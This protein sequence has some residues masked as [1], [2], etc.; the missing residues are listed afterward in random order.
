MNGL[1][2]EDLTGYLVEHEEEADFRRWLELNHE[3]IFEELLGDW[4][5][6]PA[7]WLQDRSMRTLHEWCHFDFHSLVVDMGETPIED[8]EAGS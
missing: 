5:T 8:D 3:E 4:Y 7:L 1:V 2:T 6:D